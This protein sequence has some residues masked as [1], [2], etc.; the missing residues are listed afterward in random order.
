MPRHHDEI[1]FARETGEFVN[2]GHL[3]GQGLLDKDVFT[4]EK[5][6][7]RKFEV[8]SGRRRDDDRCYFGIIANFVNRG[9]GAG[10]GKI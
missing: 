4:G 7:A 1:P 9:N 6:L 8:R 10:L 5:R 2:L 3:R